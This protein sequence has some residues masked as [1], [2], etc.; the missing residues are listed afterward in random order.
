MSGCSKG[1][2]QLHFEDG[3]IIRPYEVDFFTERSR[4]DYARIRISHEAGALLGTKADLIDTPVEITTGGE[5]LARLLFT[6]D[7]LTF[8][9][10]LDSS[11]IRLED[12]LKILERVTIDKTFGGSWSENVPFVGN[13]VTIEDV[14]D[15]LF[16]H[17]MDQ[18]DSN[19]LT[20]WEFT[21]GVDPDDV[22]RTYASSGL[23]NR[24]ADRGR[25][26]SLFEGLTNTGVSIQR[27]VNDWA[28]VGAEDA[29]FDFRDDPVLDAILH[30]CNHYSM[31]IFTKQDGIMYVGTPDLDYNHYFAGFPRGMHNLTSYSVPP[32][33]APIGGVVVKGSSERSSGE[34]MWDMGKDDDALRSE[35]VAI[36]TDLDTGSI[37]YFD[38][39]MV[40]TGDTL[41]KV[42]RRKLQET[43]ESTNNGSA[44]I[45]MLSSNPQFGNI[46]DASVG[47]YLTIPDHS[48]V[49]H[50]SS[51]PGTGRRYPGGV[52]YVSRIHHKI[53][54]RVGWNATLS[55]ADSVTMDNI[56]SY[57][58]KFD[59]TSDEFIVDGN[60]I[61]A[62]DI[63]GALG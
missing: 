51:I 13:S 31:D 35:A 36:R 41:E 34:S 63:L 24:A 1:Q 15:Y 9:E 59:P 57:S 18:V 12:C 28:D 19:A 26:G 58:Y 32:M 7:S 8:S 45:D 40:P 27:T 23:F 62:D 54:P 43:V 17:V 10:D 4:L 3:T 49:C 21:D 53:G 29:D 50:Q 52:Y 6:K 33:D 46:R 14:V 55:I 20:D 44:V 60:A 11:Y 56:T 5:R 30:V 47:D 16:D 38:D 37:L 2:A 42:A 48:E 22:P 61:E 39:R 25:I